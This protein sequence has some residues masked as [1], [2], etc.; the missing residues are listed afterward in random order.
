MGV[1][2]EQ[3]FAEG[4]HKRHKYEYAKMQLM[5][6]DFPEPLF[7]GKSYRLE[8]ESFNASIE[9]AYFWMLNY[10]KADLGFARI[11]KITDLFSASEHSAFFGVAQQRIGLQQDKVI[12]FLATIG[13]MIKDLF[14][15][16]RELRII[17]ERLGYYKLSDSKDYK[18]AEPA[19]I[20]LK[21]LYIDMAEGGAKS[22]AS[23]YGMAR[24][25]QFT[26][27]P[28]LFF[29]T[30]PK[31]SED[32]GKVVDSLDFNKSVKHILKR[33]LFS[34]L[35][36]KEETRKELD[37]RRTFT[38]R[39]L[40]QHFDIIRM[41]IA[42]TKPYLRNLKRL[43]MAD[44]AG[45]SELVSAF[46][47]SLV[48]IEILGVYDLAK[49]KEVMACLSIHFEYRSQPSMN[50]QQEGYQRGPIHVGRVKIQY[51]S[52]AWTEKDIEE[53][54]SMRQSED[55]ELMSSIDGSLK[56]AMEALGDDLQKYLDEAEKATK[57]KPQADKPVYTN[58]FFSA[59]LGFRDTFGALAPSKPKGEKE[60]KYKK[61][62][63]IANVKKAIKTMMWLSYK[64]FK[65]GHR[66]VTW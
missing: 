31:R 21:G 60:D 5:E 23:V 27:L 39:Y 43:N 19:M 49:N 4:K 55:L 58:P 30:N 16:V 44:K 29:G 65:K 28:D 6:S 26:T 32:V 56:A 53:Y 47:G 51:R 59:I 10:M 13:K 18:V 36:W 50:Y 46:E 8:Y 37:A 2:K 33:K 24:E 62:K 40:K 42:W 54:K 1:T 64:Q 45:S 15:L 11:D 61:D 38:L 14:Q 57:S 48:E 12:Q 52:Y 20:T 66:M 25:L 35:R 41:Y 7:D 17:D 3:Y 9:E 63:E 22:P 34:F